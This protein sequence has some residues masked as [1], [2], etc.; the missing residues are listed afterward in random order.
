MTVK[1]IP[2]GLCASSDLDFFSEDPVVV[3]SAQKL[4]IECP[5]RVDCLL[6]AL[7]HGDRFGVW[8][9]ATETDIRRA[10]S[11][12]QYGKPLV[13]EKSMRC[14]MCGSKEVTSHGSKR[15][16][17]KRRCEDCKLT[18]HSRMPSRTI[19]IDVEEDNDN[20]ERDI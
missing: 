9:G 2:D 4:C 11:I 10:L 13:R 14:P 17:K 1:T 8:G 5:A 12:D 16:G 7:A 20:L 15:I 19:K 6:S 18:W 3:V